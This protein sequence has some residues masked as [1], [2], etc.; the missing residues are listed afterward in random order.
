MTVRQWYVSEALHS[1]RRLEEIIDE[2]SQE[3]IIAALDLESGSRRRKS[4]INRLI[5]KAVRLNE[6]AYSN[7]LKEFYHGTYPIESSV[8]S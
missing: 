3:E 1:M 6:L 4:I 8:R 7:K 2:L 5:S